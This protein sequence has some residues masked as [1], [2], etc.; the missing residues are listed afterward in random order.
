MIPFYRTPGTRIDSLNP[1]L[2]FPR[3][4]SIIFLNSLLILLDCVD[5]TV[6]KEKHQACVGTGSFPK[7]I[8]ESLNIMG[9]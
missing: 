5:K 7:T 3:V 1:V 6:S 8:K 4:F 9:Q 2:V